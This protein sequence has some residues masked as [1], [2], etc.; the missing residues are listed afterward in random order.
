[1]L[2]SFYDI[3]G[4]IFIENRNTDRR[5]VRVTTAMNEKKRK[6]IKEERNRRFKEGRKKKTKLAERK[7]G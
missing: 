2:L 7:C 6:T 3:F 4:D 5:C 1:M